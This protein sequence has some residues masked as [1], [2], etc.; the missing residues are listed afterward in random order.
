LLES[1]KGHGALPVCNITLVV[2]RV[3]TPLDWSLKRMEPKLA[4]NCRKFTRFVTRQSGRC[5]ARLILWFS[6]DTVAPNALIM[7]GLGM[8]AART[9]SML[10]ASS[11]LKKI[12]R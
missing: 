11:I 9:L 12:Q 1:K 3:F 8:P 2:R 7:I 5:Y 10:V 6:T 4:A